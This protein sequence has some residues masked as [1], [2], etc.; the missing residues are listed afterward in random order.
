MKTIVSLAEIEPGDLI[1]VS[2]D[3]G[4]IESA[5]FTRE[6]VKSNSSS[7]SITDGDETWS[8]EPSM[9]NYDKTVEMKSGNF[10]HIF[11]K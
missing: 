1:E 7:L 9:E 8:I 4:G 10:C 5:P 11:H 2:S 3:S 6:V